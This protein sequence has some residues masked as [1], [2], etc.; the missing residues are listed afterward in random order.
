MW[1]STHFTRPWEE[2]VKPDGTTIWRPTLFVLL[3]EA[4]R[5]KPRRFLLDSGADLSLASRSICN[6]LDLTWE[7]GE[8]R[9][10]HGISHKEECQ[11]ESR[12][13]AVDL[14][15]AELGIQITIPMCFAEGEAPLVLGREGFFEYFR[16]TFDRQALLTTFEFVGQLL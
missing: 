8:K 10:L 14:V 7:A 12:V 9:T 13:H 15:V 16:V 3:W 5:L 1:S 11:V 6:H 2:F 4:D